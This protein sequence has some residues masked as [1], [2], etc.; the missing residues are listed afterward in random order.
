MPPAIA[1]IIKPYDLYLLLIVGLIK[2]ADRSRSLRLK[3]LLARAVATA[4]FRLSPRRRRIREEAFS[5]ILPHRKQDIRRL[6]KHSFFE[7]WYDILSLTPSRTDRN[8]ARFEARGLQHLQKALDR[9][10]GVIL[11]ESHFFGRR[12]LAK[13]ILHE[14]SYSVSPVHVETHLGGFRNTKTW[15]SKH[16][17]RRF[18]DRREKAFV[19]EVISLSRSESLTYARALL[20]RLK[21]NDILCVAADGR[22]GYKFVSVEFLGRRERFSTGMVSLARLTGASILPLFCIPGDGDST[23]LIIE[24]PIATESGCNREESVETSVRHYAS[25]FESYIRSYPGLYRDWRLS[26]TPAQKPLLSVPQRV[27]GHEEPCIASRRDRLRQSD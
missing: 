11:W 23:L 25:L 27:S 21:K 6:V 17:I 8:A 22:V 26:D 24:P 5:Q 2:I 15:V 10:N 7:F 9:G 4:A 13:R 18:L 20:D 19:K 12:E 14:H 16:L 3:R 1:G